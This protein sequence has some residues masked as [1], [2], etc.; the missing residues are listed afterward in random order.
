MM[1]GLLLV[2]AALPSAPHA[3]VPPFVH[4]AAQA[5]SSVKTTSAMLIAWIGITLDL[6][7]GNVSLAL[8]TV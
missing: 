1:Q 8:T 7:L 4:F 2:S 5:T 6:P 3:L